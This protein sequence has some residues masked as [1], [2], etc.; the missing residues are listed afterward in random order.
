MHK[1]GWDA[2]NA[3]GCLRIHSYPP[4]RMVTSSC[5]AARW[6]HTS[7]P[8][9]DM[10]LAWKAALVEVAAMHRVTHVQL[11]QPVQLQEQVHTEHRLEGHVLGQLASTLAVRFLYALC[12][13]GSS[14]R[15]PCC[16]CSCL[17]AYSSPAPRLPV[18]TMKHA[19]TSSQLPCHA[20]TSHPSPVPSGPTMQ[21]TEA[22]WCTCGK[23]P[24][25]WSQWEGHVHWMWKQRAREELVYRNS[26]NQ[27]Y[28]PFTPISKILLFCI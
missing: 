7:T 9:I 12:I 4:A 1:C 6:P 22:S 18:P 19:Y 20:T 8:R 17:R 3:S 10:D 27:S 14:S 21:A 5:R 16:A 26:K 25:P 28:S 2:G 24:R 23:H 15:S 11:G 13:V